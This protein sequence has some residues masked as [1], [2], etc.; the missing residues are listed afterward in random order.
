MSE[1]EASGSFSWAKFWRDL[2][3]LFPPLRNF[4]IAR[5]DFSAAS[6]GFCFLRLMLPSLSGASTPFSVKGDIRLM[7]NPATWK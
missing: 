7:G 2:L 5:L 6:V 1:V 4:L 3:I